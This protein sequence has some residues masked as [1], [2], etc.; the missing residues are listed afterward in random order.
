[1][2]EDDN[3]NNNNKTVMTTTTT[4]PT[5]DPAVGEA[6]GGGLGGGQTSATSH[7]RRPASLGLEGT[8]WTR[9]AWHRPV[10]R[11]VARCAQLCGQYNNNTYIFYS[12]FLYRYFQ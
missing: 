2:V 6:R 9:P 11:E 10:G 1:M 7:A 8:R 5:S 12:A 4:A 3:S